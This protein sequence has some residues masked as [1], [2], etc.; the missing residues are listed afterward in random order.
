MSLPRAIHFWVGGVNTRGNRC[1]S[2][3]GQEQRTHI[4]FQ[5]HLPVL[6]SPDSLPRGEPSNPPRNRRGPAAGKP[7]GNDFPDARG[8]QALS[9]CRPPAG[10]AGATGPAA[11]LRD[12]CLHSYSRWKI[13]MAVPAHLYTVSSLLRQV[14]RKHSRVEIS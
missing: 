1:T 6:N 4:Y 9:N 7:E 3:S 12:S 2:T 13:S 8:C 14:G 11:G 5:R 10:K